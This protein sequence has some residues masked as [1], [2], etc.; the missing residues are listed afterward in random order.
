MSNNTENITT[1][2]T[3]KH[4][5][6]C[7]SKKSCSWKIHRHVYV[8]ELYP[9]VLER[10]D[11][12]QGDRDRVTSETRFFY[13]GQTRHRVG[14]R[15]LQHRARKARRASAGS[16]FDCSCKTGACIKTP[17]R[18]WNKGNKFVRTYAL[19]S[20]ALRPEFF[21]HHNPVFGGKEAALDMEQ[22]VAQKLRDRGHLV[23]CDRRE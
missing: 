7:G 23:H 5:P 20:G 12:C 16:T 14:C 17:F 3:W 22:H 19:K 6:Q 1:P 10:R 18:L 9:T 11:F 8:V 4:C 13:V 2:T 21:F 15:Y